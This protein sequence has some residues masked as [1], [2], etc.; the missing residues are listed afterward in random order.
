MPRPHPPQRQDHRL[1]RHRPRPRHP[2]QER[3]LRRPPGRRRVREPWL[4]SSPCAEGSG[5]RIS[6]TLQAPDGSA[7]HRDGAWHH[8]TLVR[9]GDQVRLAVDGTT[10][11]RTGPTG[12]LTSPRASGVDGIRLGAKPADGSD[13]F[14]GSL[15]GLG[16]R[17]GRRRTPALAA[18]R[19]R[20]P[21][22]RRPRPDRERRR[23]TAY[24]PDTP[25]RTGAQWHHVVL[26]REGTRLTLSIDGVSGTPGTVPAGSLTTATPST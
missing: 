1:V 9:V 5:S 22:P 11:T 4:R 24:A 8:L 13:T 19:T 18:G 6:L 15:D 12:S 26:Q 20:L 14:T 25:F 23:P 3:P 17:H 2:A 16:L 10:V 21:P 7:A